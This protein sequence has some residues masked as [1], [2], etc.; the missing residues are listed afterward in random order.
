M[1]R[2]LSLLLLSSALMSTVLAEEK[3]R[4]SKD[5]DGS[6]M[7]KAV[8]ITEPDLDR[9]VDLQWK[10]FHQHAPLAGMNGAHVM[11]MGGKKPHTMYQCFEFYLPSGEKKQMWFDMSAAFYSDP[12]GERHASRKQ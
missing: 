12:K 3:V 11:L 2:T 1:T 7:D 6:T 8:V 5:H 4:W 9:S 10:Y